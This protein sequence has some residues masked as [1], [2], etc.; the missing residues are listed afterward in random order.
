MSSISEAF[1]RNVLIAGCVLLCLG[2]HEKG[3]FQVFPSAA[4]GVVWAGF[5]ISRGAGR[6]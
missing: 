5:I 3:T 1:R 2:K 6:P 4:V